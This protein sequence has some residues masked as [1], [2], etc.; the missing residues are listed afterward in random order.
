MNLKFVLLIAAFLAK[1]YL[2]ITATSISVNAEVG[3]DS[4]RFGLELRR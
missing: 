4:Q 1:I 2:F 3:K